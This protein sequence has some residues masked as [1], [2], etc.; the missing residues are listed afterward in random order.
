MLA[1]I[2]YISINIPFQFPHTPTTTNFPQQCAKLLKCNT[3]KVLSPFEK[4]SFP[5]APNSFSYWRILAVMQSVIF[6]AVKTNKMQMVGD[7][8]LVYTTP[9]G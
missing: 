5:N 6:G 1:C 7:S 2:F 4:I 9:Y 8:S 3:G